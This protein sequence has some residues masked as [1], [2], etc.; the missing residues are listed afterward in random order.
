M[1]L[2]GFD[3]PREIIKTVG[4]ALQ[5]DALK[6]LGQ[7]S[8]QCFVAGKA[9]NIK[10]NVLIVHESVPREALLHILPVQIHLGRKLR[11]PRVGEILDGLFDGESFQ[12]FAQFI[13]LIRL[14]QSNFFTGKT[15]IR[16]E[17][18][19]PLL[20]QSGQ[21]FANR[22]STHTEALTEFLVVKLLARQNLVAQN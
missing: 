2:M 10:M 4:S 14:L 5:D 16:Q 22:R 12:G 7:G 20:S 3:A 17:G 18:D 13:K 1:L 21:C 8:D 9:G 11:Q 6:N 19:I 15:P